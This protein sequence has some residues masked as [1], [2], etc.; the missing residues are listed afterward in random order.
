MRKVEDYLKHAEECRQMA[1]NTNSEEHRQ[2][3]LQMASTW[4]GL[5][6]DRK[7]QIERQKRIGLLDNLAQ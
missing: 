7:E 3:L 1:S 4:E 6:V 2:M 5:A